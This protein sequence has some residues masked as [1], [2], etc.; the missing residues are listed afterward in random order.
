[1]PPSSTL[2]RGPCNRRCGGGLAYPSGQFLKDI[3]RHRPCWA[4]TPLP[5]AALT[6]YAASPHPA[7]RVFPSLASTPTSPWGCP[8]YPRPSLKVGSR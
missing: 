1:M 7:Q 8:R 2:S 4:L 5:I 6:S 3:F